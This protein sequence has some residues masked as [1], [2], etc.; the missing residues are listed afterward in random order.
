MHNAP[1]AMYLTEPHKIYA[2]SPISTINIKRSGLN[3]KTMSFQLQSTS[4]SGRIHH[5]YYV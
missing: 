4:N 1:A 2:D 3:E 5:D